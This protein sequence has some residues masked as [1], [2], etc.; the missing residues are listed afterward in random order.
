M[1]INEKTNHQ[2][3]C[4]LC[5]GTKFKKRPGSVRDN[6]ELEVFECASCGLVFLS[7]FDH[8]KDGFYENSEMH[9]KDVLDIQTWTRETEWDDER[10]FQYLKSALPNQR[11]L[12]FGC[13]TGGFLLKVQDLAATVHGIELETRLNS[14]YKSRD[15]TIFKN[16]SD[17]QSDIR[18][19]G[20]DIITMFHVLE[21]IPDPKSILVELS[22][23]LAD[24]G[25]IIVEVPNADDALLTLYKNKPFSN[26]TYWSCHLFLFTAKT[27][28]ILFSQVNLKVNYIKQ[29]QRYPLANHLYWLANG[30]PGGHQKWHFLNSP[31]LH[32]AYEKQ[33]AAIGKCDTILASV[34]R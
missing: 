19:K 2:N 34:S 23:I 29:I 24:G 4:Y 21:H 9:G 1:V 25:Q 16:L 32:A 5:G 22:E 15:L 11:L 28:K 3:K 27:L 18:R 7:S 8:I 10:R 13:G 17:I 30:K 31:E 14:H 33:L 6:P 12:D 20:Y 26:F